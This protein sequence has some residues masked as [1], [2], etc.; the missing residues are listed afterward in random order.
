M[1][2]LRVLSGPPPK[3]YLDLMQFNF[4]DQTWQQLRIP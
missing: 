2:Q 4:A 1:T 3:S